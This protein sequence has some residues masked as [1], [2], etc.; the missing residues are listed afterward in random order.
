MHKTRKEICSPHS[1]K[2]VNTLEEKFFSNSL[3][4]KKLNFV[5]LSKLYHACLDQLNVYINLPFK[6]ADSKH[7]TRKQKIQQQ[8]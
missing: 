3:S 4:K 1:T 7:Y 6:F 2:E 5:R 8:V